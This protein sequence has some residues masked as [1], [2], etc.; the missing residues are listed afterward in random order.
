VRSATGSPRAD[1]SAGT[2]QREHDEHRAENAAEVELVLVAD[3]KQICDQHPAHEHADDA[4]CTV[5]TN[6]SGRGLE[7]AHA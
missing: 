2:S 3:A 5:A 6:P 1:P 4:D 7:A